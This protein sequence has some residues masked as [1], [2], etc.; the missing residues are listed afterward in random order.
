MDTSIDANILVVSSS[1]ALAI[2]IKQISS[3]FNELFLRLADNYKLLYTTHI[4]S[5]H[6][7]YK[8]KTH[9]I[10]H[11]IRKAN[12]EDKI[13][14]IHGLEAVFKSTES[15]NGLKHSIEEFLSLLQS[16]LSDTN[17]TIALSV[18][19]LLKILILNL[20]FDFES[21]L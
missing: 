13:S 12:W 9:R 6:P 3:N 10:I 4:E 18:L 5:Y 16:L 15:F 2:H 1:K 8:P 19:G 20:E 11:Y 7:L 21:I 17:V 14:A